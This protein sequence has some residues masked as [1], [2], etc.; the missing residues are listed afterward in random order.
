MI[1][2][3]EGPVAK[4]I[5]R[6]TMNQKIGDSSPSRDRAGGISSIGR[7]RAL[8]AR[9]TGIET[10]MLQFCFL[11]QQKYGAPPQFWSIPCGLD[12]RAV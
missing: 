9:G 4:R 5:R 11:T 7:V 10:L 1:F 2:I 12:G 3:T 6:L 8:Q